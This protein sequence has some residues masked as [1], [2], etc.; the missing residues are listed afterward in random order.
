MCIREAM[1]YKPHFEFSFHAGSREIYSANAFV[2]IEVVTCKLCHKFS[3]GQVV[4]VMTDIWMKSMF[5]AIE[6]LPIIQL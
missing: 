3:C 6:G 4:I 1:T 5:Y 2:H